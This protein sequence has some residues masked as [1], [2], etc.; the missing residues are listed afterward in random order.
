MGK[1]ESNR[2]KF[3]QRLPEKLKRW[4]VLKQKNHVPACRVCPGRLGG[5]RD[6][7]GRAAQVWVW[8]PL[9]VRQLLGPG[10]KAS[11]GGG[12]SRPQEKAGSE[13]QS[14]S[15]TVIMGLHQS[16]LRV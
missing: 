12:E 1:S 6:R 8:L 15:P 5:W 14:R 11:A 2:G 9:W 3:I 16:W 13:G 7:P 4:L 10:G